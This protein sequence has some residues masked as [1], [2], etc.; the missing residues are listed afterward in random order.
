[1]TKRL[2]EPSDSLKDRLDLVVA[3]YGPNPAVWPNDLREDYER[4]K[5]SSDIQNFMAQTAEVEA[6]LA[7]ER[8]TAP[9]GDFMTKLLNIPDQAQHGRDRFM[10]LMTLFGDL[11]DLPKLGSVRGLALQTAVLCVVFVAGIMLGD[12][13][14]DN[15]ADDTIDLM[16]YWDDADAGFDFDT[17]GNGQ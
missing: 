7:R 10:R 5:A 4:F 9:D 17:E 15:A 11:F 1:M 8:L 14:P 3:T 12:G 16:A 13:G 6:A 2:N